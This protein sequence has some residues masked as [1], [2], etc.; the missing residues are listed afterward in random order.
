MVQ[1]FQGELLTSSPTHSL[2]FSVK[3]LIWVK[4]NNA[5][6]T[7]TLIHRLCTQTFSPP[8]KPNALLG[9]KPAAP[10]P[11]QSPSAVEMLSTTLIHHLRSRWVSCLISIAILLKL[12]CMALVSENHVNLIVVDGETSRFGAYI[13]ESVDSICRDSTDTQYMLIQ[14]NFSKSPKRLTYKPLQHPIVH[15]RVFS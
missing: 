11:I 9:I 15:F 8:Q 12:P 5:V 7:P 2:S 13:I 14:T 6:R 10:P 3:L 4:A 1:S